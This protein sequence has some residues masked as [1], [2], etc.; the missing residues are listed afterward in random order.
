MKKAYIIVLIFTLFISVTGCEEE[1]IALHCDGENCQNIV[2]V[3]VDSSR[4]PDESWVVF[5]QDCATSDLAD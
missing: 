4:K 5:C 1:K 2:D 3:V